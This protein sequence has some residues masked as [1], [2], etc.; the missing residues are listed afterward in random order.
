MLE[1]MSSDKKTVK[2]AVKDPSAMTWGL[3]DVS[4]SNAG[5][6]TDTIMHK[7]RRGQKVTLSLAWNGPTPAEAS[8]I[9]QAFNPEYIFLRY[10][11]PLTNTK[12][13]KEFYVGDR[14]AP[15]K[16]W[17]SNNKLYETVSFEVIER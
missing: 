17:Q 15:V 11:D 8:A 14:S 7:D 1:I 12:T 9:L 2:T 3:K 13:T 16:V 5:R 6:T 4:G 10:T